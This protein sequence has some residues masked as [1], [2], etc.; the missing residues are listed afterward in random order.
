MPATRTR[1]PMSPAVQWALTAGGIWLAFVAGTW[2][3]LQFRPIPLHWLTASYAGAAFA[4]VLYA[5]ARRWRGAPLAAVVVGLAVT[6]WFG[7]PAVQ[8]KVSKATGTVMQKV[9]DQTKTDSAKTGRR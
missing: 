6:V 3:A 1:A 9:S 5:S 4:A 7:S 8:A 2:V